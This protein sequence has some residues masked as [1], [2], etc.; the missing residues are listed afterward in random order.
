MEVKFKFDMKKKVKDELGN[1]GV[2]MNAAI[3]RSGTKSYYLRTQTGNGAWFDEDQL[4]L[5]Q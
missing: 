5:A 2:I 1:V 4:E 3:D